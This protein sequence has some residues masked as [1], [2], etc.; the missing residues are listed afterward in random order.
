MTPAEI[1]AHQHAKAPNRLNYSSSPVD[2]FRVLKDS[3]KE[4]LTGVSWGPT[5]GTL[6]TFVMTSTFL[7]DVGITK[8]SLDS[9]EVITGAL[10]L[11]ASLTTFLAPILGSVG[12][13]AD[14]SPATGLTSVVLPYL[15]SVG[16]NLKLNIA[17]LTRIVLDS[18]AT[19]NGDLL[20]DGASITSLS[21]PALT[22]VGGATKKLSAVNCASLTT[23][24]IPAFVPV[25]D[26]VVTFAGCALT[27][28]SVNHILARCVAAGITSGT[29]TLTGG[30][31][32]VPTG[33]GATDLAALIAAGVTATANS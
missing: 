17:N 6:P 13:A 11:G 1:Q 25:N 3:E 5:D 18:L 21:L 15:A 22:A 9:V 2:G 28:A 10:T 29:V 19:V 8:V 23:V 7:D 33:Q 31:N 26:N 12:G 4:A 20:F 16:G 24:S 14:L 30:T 32:A 27:A